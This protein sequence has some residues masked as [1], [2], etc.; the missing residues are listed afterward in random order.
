VLAGGQRVCVARLTPK[1]L[2]CNGLVV[3]HRVSDQ[4][5]WPV[6]AGGGQ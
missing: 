1:A 4:S 6:S 3:E 2:S 5:R